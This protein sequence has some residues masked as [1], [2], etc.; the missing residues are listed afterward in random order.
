MRAFGAVAAG[1]IIVVVLSSVTDAWMH[2]LAVF[3]PAGQPMS[4][5]QWGL[6]IAYRVVFTILGGMACARLAPNRPV[7]YG[8]V[9]GIVGTCIGTIAAFATWNSGPE[10]GPKWFQVMLAISALPSAWIGAKW[11]NSRRGS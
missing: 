7:A 9:L 4:N 3:P 5:W 11:S 8:V 6:A 10:F 1:I 2:G